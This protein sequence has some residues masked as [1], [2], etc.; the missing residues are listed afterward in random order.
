MPNASP[1]SATSGSVFTIAPGVCFVDALAAALLAE[2]HAEPLALTRYTILLP[3]RRARRSLAEAFLRQGDGRPLLLPRMMPLGDLDPDEAELF[4]S[5]ETL[6]SGDSGAELPPPI[7]ALRRQLLLMRAVLATDP[8]NITADQ[9]ARL[10]AELARFLDQM[11]TEQV[12]FHK[13]KNLVPEEYAVHWQRTL[14]FLAILTEAWPRILAEEGCIDPALRRNQVLAAQ[15]EFWRAQPPADPVIAAGSTGSIP[16]TAALLEVVAG[17]PNGRVVLPGLDREADET[18]GNA[19]LQDVTHPQHGMA[20]LLQRLSLTPADVREWPCRLR[21]AAPPSRARLL[22]EAL[23]PAETTDRW[24]TLAQEVKADGARQ[25]RLKLALRGVSRI[26]CAN[27]QEEAQIIALQM[28]GVLQTEG[29]RAALVTPD[30]GLA[31]RVAA[32]LNSLGHRG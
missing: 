21:A 27:P 2:T 8:R 12:S 25:E 14:R 6:P 3:T 28:R 22:N 26:D 31:R 10:A 4:G 1:S 23:R 17:L 29:K 15:A 7:P 9:A 13:L 18:T 32:E 24:Q 20:R 19:I 30:R 11:Q 5:D 16:A